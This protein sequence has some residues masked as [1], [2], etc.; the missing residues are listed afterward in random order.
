MPSTFSTPIDKFEFQLL[1]G[2]EW[3]KVEVP[4]QSPDLTNP[5]AFLA[6]AVFIHQPTEGVLSIA[7]RPGYTDGTVLDWLE[8]L[9][10]GE[11]F[12]VQAYMPFQMGDRQAAS[13]IAVQINNDARVK[14]RCAAL[15]DGGNLLTITAMAP[16]EK[17][18][19]FGEMVDPIMASFALTRP[20]GQTVPLTRDD[21][22]GVERSAA[23]IEHSTSNVE[24]STSNVQ[25]SQ[26]EMDDP[27][28]AAQY[29]PPG[30]QA[31][32]GDIHTYAEF[33]L[34]D[35]ESTLLPDDPINANFRNL[36]A[37]LAPNI[38]SIDRPARFAT[39]GA[40]AIAAL[41]RVP[42]GWNAIDDGRRT[43][44][45]DRQN[46]VQINFTLLAPDH[47]DV[48]EIFS[49]ILRDI[50]EANPEAK[51][52]RLDLDGL[53]AMVVR[54]QIIDGAPIEQAYVLKPL[55]HAPGQFLKVRMSGPAS[56]LVRGG[57]LLELMLRDLQFAGQ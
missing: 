55:P 6:L 20:A 47:N 3:I 46:D 32:S 34:S 28:D 1:I 25:Q 7:G 24:R 10:H 35:N 39:I 33:A 37:G 18:P 29:S 11:R 51:Y 50:A 23:N 57:N 54:G 9:A 38:L 48:E 13:C 41:L 19:G 26:A 4:P 49:S 15:E 31:P 21:T 43:L 36:G 17:W 16:E 44:I 30:A 14:L 45:F 2:P 5:A 8:F 53:P 56:Q 40:G 12:E 27:I 42:L 22:S 52:Q